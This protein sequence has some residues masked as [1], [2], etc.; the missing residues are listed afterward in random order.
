MKFIFSLIFSCST[1]GLIA[2]S[3]PTDLDDVIQTAIENNYNIKIAKN[4]IERAVGN[5]TIGAAGW[6]PTADVS[7]NYTYTNNNTVTKFNGNIPDQDVQGAASHNY[8]ANVNLRYTLFD[9]LKP[10]YTFQKS[11]IEIQLMNTQHRQSIEN[12]IYSVLQAYYQLAALEEDYAITT[13]KMKLTKVQLTRIENQRKYG[14]GSEV[15]RLNLQ[16]TFNQDST[17]LLRI[18]LSKRQAMRQLNKAIGTEKI[19][20]NTSVKV[21]TDLDLS[22]NYENILAVAKAN[23]LTLRQAGQNIQ[24][25]QLDY[26]ITQSEL[27]P[28]L[29]STVSY[30]YNGSQND[31]GIVSSNSSLGLT[32]NLGLSYTFYGGGRLK[33]ARQAAEINIKNAELN[34][35]LAAYELEQTIK[36]AWTTHQ[37]NM[38]LI[39]IEENNVLISQKS[40]E[41]TTKAYQLGQTSYLS[42][43]QAELIYLQAK[44]QVVSAKHNAK[45]SEWEL[46]RIAGQLLK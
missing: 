25:A 35:E 3:L 22:I 21:N 39:P 41:R 29:N 8:G 32:V 43:Q 11:K 27:Y 7:G 2:Q 23:N 9:G 1:L 40:F 28:K 44:R 26:K 12:T 14:Q 36:D 5:S 10:M 17:Q 34:E 33:P 18:L 4:N 16:T 38:A 13:E 46:R 30:G 19:N 24:K 6:L 20:E 31:A 42:Y 45:L 37:N 15:E